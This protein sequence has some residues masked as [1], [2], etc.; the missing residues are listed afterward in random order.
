MKLAESSERR[1]ERRTKSRP[2]GNVTIAP[3][4]EPTA[5]QPLRLWP[6]VVIV[7]LLA[8]AL[9]RRPSS[10]RP[11][12]A[13]AVLG[14]PIGALAIV[15]WWVFF[16][17]APWSERVGAILLMIVALAAT[18]YILHESVRTGNMGI[19]FFLYASR[20]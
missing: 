8:L 16:S 2:Q 10:A 15:V 18:P 7:V 13:F 9:V 14:G 19:Q 4:D 5:Q 12:S 1:N 20:S 11:T 17:R 6:G 3:T